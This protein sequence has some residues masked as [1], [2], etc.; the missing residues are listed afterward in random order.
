M[1]TLSCETIS[2]TERRVSFTPQY[3]G[4]NGQAVTFSSAGLMMPTTSPG[5]YTHS[6][7]IDNPTVTL[8]AEQSG[9]AVSFAYSWLAAC[10]NPGSTPPPTSTTP[11][12]TPSGGSLVLLAPL[13]NCSTGAITFQ[14]SGG[15]GTTIEFRSPGITDWSSNPNQY[16]DQDARTAGDTPPFTLYARQSGQVVT[17]SWSR[18]AT[19]SGGGRIS[20]QESQPLLMMQVLGNPVIN[21]TATVEIQGGVGQWLRLRLFDARGNTISETLIPQPQTVEQHSFKLGGPTGLY[22]LQVSTPTQAQAVKL[23]KQ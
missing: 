1:S 14:T 9:T 21:E 12:P 6:I 16:L 17:Y 13:Y 7:F 4:L 3:S 19:C 11:P 23:L 15:N 18:Q 8:Q 5:P 22:I 2:A 20:T 10:N